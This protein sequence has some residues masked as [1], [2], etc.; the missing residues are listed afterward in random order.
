MIA[1]R[2]D[3]LVGTCFQIKQKAVQTNRMLLLKLSKRSLSIAI[4][5]Y[6]A[7]A[8]LMSIVAMH[9]SKRDFDAIANYF[10]L[11]K[12]SAIL[13]GLLIESKL[14]E[15]SAE[16]STEELEASQRV[17]SLDNNKL[18][19][20]ELVAYEVLGDLLQYNYK[21]TERSN[22]SVYYRSY[23]GKKLV[24]AKPNEDYKIS[25]QMFDPLI[26]GPARICSLN[27]HE[28]E[29]ADRV[30]ISDSYLGNLGTDTFTVTSPVYKNDEIIGD[31]VVDIRVNYDHLDGRTVET[32]LVNGFYYVTVGFENYPF[33]NFAG[34]LILP[35]DNDSAIIYQLPIIKVLIDN[36][37]VLFVTWAIVGTFHRLYASNVQHRSHLAHAIKNA[38]IDELTSLYNRKVF[39]DSDFENAIK[40][41]HYAVILIDGKKFKQINDTH[42]HKAGD[43]ALIHIARTMKSTFRQSDWLIRLGGDEFVVVMP[44]CPLE[45]AE[46][47][48][49]N[50]RENIVAR[51]LVRF[52]ISVQVTT[53]VAKA[54]SEETLMD[55]IER[56]DQDMYQYKDA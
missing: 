14:D 22:I 19:N 51:P 6:L 24:F 43:L 42:G 50:L 37:W 26:C 25:D 23:L 35:I 27:M 8:S 1:K 32:N 46:R 5:V 16:I 41:G 56:A 15:P 49:T 45:S 31:V 9:Q 18:T 13:A 52:G 47:L 48:A 12:S 20:D 3:E 28:T 21:L 34:A 44:L 11:Y 30:V 40:E 4:A 38:S 54:T 53:G 55:V 10:E 33:S 36:L 39:E 29:L 7:V 17:Q 2:I